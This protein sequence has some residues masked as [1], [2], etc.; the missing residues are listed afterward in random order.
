MSNVGVRLESFWRPLCNWLLAHS[1]PV[2]A[3]GFSLDLDST[4]FQRSGTQQ[5]AKR[6]Y[7]PSRLGRHSHHPLLAFLAEAPLVLHA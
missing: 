1:W 6:G 2:P 3:E 4:V 7:N 5:G